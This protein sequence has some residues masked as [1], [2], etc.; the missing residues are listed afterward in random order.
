MKSCWRWTLPTWRWN[1]NNFSVLSRLHNFKAVW[2]HSIKEKFK[3]IVKSNHLSL[4]QLWDQF[5]PSIV[6]LSRDFTAVQNIFPAESAVECVNFFRVHSSDVFRVISTVFRPSAIYNLW[7]YRNGVAGWCRREE[8]Q[9]EV[10]DDW[11][12]DWIS[13]I[14]ALDLE[15][16]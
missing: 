9:P 3:K 12:F 2:A 14:I 6:S 7:S 10:S 16:Q 13:S 8:S 11:Q 5:A 15:P 1:L 4:S